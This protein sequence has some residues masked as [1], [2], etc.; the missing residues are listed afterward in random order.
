MVESFKF[1]SDSSGESQM[2]FFHA[3]ELVIV[4]VWPSGRAVAFQATY[5]GSIPVTRSI[6]L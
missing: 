5:T 4:R 3:I 1:R 2:V 6:K